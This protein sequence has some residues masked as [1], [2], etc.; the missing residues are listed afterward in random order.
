MKTK[1][2][3]QKMK[4]KNDE[5]KAAWVKES[6]NSG[7]KMPKSASSIVLLL[8]LL[9]VAGVCL[10]FFSYFFPSG[11]DLG[12]A[13]SLG[14]AKASEFRNRAQRANATLNPI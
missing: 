5:N 8:L 9:A 3:K 1:E 11:R 12:Q 4:T 6:R 13:D 14:D 7:K 2:S 10:P